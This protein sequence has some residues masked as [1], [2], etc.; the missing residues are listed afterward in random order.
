MADLVPSVGDL[1]DIIHPPSEYDAELDDY[2]A[3]LEQYAYDTDTED[4]S[5]LI[6]A[7]DGGEVDGLFAPG[8]LPRDAEHADRLLARAIV[9]QERMAAVQAAQRAYIARIH[10]WAAAATRRDAASL[11]FIER[12]LEAYA[13]VVRSET[14]VKTIHLPA[15]SIATRQ[16]AKPKVVL[17]DE[18]AFLTWLD[19]NENLTQEERN[20]IVKRSVRLTQMRELVTAVQDPKT[21]EWRPVALDGSSPDGVKLDDGFG[22]TLRPAPSL[23]ELVDDPLEP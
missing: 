23:A 1:A 2:L 20:L 8:L 15:G 13:A 19:T 17:A 21:K 16:A 6:D 10:E 4:V 22:V 7:I 14:G 12:R 11:E 18:A 5:D 3:Q 9:R